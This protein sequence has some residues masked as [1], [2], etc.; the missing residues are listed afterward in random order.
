MRLPANTFAEMREMVEYTIGGILVETSGKG[1]HKRAD[2]TIIYK[3][4]NTAVIPFPNG[5]E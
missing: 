1:K 4:C 5:D 3:V 2:F